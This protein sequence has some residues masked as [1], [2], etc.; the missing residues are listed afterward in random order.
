[1]D[2]GHAENVHRAGS[3]IHTQISSG[4]ASRRGPPVDPLVRR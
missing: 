3:D 2:S 1:M 4:N